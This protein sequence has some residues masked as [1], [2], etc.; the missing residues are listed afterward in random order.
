MNNAEEVP[1]MRVDVRLFIKGM[2]MGAADVVPGVSGGTVAF[3]TGIYEQLIG[4]LG[5]IDVTALTLFFSGKLALFWHHINGRFLVT[6][7]GGILFSIFSLAKLISWVLEHHPKIIWAYFFG[8]IVASAITIGKQIRL[9]YWRNLAALMV[10]ALLAFSLTRITQI[11]VEPTLGFVFIS[12]AI[13]ICAMILPGISGSFILVLLGMYHTVIEAIKSLDG[14]LLLVFAAG[15]VTGL[16]SFT[17][18]LAWL[19]RNFHGLTLA[20]LTGF[21]LGSLNKV[22]PWK[23]QELLPGGIR[24]HNLLPNQYQAMQQADPQ[25][26]AVLIALI[27]GLATV[28]IINR[29]GNGKP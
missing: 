2:A 15:C 26:F 14:S 17:H 11:Q 12:G 21:M 13:A 20:V 3:I 9:T 18:L 22:W 23:Y 28:Y 16:L 8:L 24:E 25:L 1:K 19:L 6:L 10:A 27:L 5:S 7:F 4:A 29:A